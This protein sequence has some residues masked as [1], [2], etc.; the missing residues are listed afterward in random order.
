MGCFF[1]LSSMG[2]FTDQQQKRF[3]YWMPL[4][5]YSIGQK[6][7]AVSIY[8]YLS[9]SDFSL[10]HFLFSFSIIFLFYFSV[11]LYVFSFLCEEIVLVQFGPAN[12]VYRDIYAIMRTL[13]LN[14]YS[15]TNNKKLHKQKNISFAVQVISRSACESVTT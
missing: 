5:F 11:Y 1:T 7:T 15:K 2:D 8:L 14:K 10:L 9:I 4:D 13:S 3:R 12:K 6:T